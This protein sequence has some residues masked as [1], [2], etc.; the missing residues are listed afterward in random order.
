M[1][2]VNFVDLPE[3]SE[4]FKVVQIYFK[5][6]PFLLCGDEAILESREYYHEKILRKFLSSQGLKVEIDYKLVVPD[7]KSPHVR[8]P[9]VKVNELYEV[10]GAGFAIIDSKNY[11][12]QLPYGNSVDYKKLGILGVNE[13]FNKLI[14]QTLKTQ[15]KEWFRTDNAI[16]DDNNKKKS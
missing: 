14:K 4:E 7:P 13:E 9:P 3:Y 1:T 10:V 2:L 11:Y 16:S 8:I 12:F 15:S 6:K 5:K